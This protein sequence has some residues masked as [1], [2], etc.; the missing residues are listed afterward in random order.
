MFPF[1]I[2]PAKAKGQ[3]VK[4]DINSALVED[5]ISL[6]EVKEDM[7]AVLSALKDEFTRS[8]SIRTSP[9][10]QSAHVSWTVSNAVCLLN[11][12]NFLSHMLQVQNTAVI[13]EVNVD[14][15][16]R[17]QNVCIKN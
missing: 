10:S 9:G 15:Y 16:S 6:E 11:P 13:D 5:I 3:S 4:V 14:I 2:I 1:F 17:A 7:N 12:S 8:L